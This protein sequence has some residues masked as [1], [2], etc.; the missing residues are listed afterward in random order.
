MKHKLES[1]YFELF[2]GQFLQIFMK[3]KQFYESK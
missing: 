3:K 2:S 1:L